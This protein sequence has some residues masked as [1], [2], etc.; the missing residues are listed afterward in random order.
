VK[1]TADD[2]VVATVDDAIPGPRAVVWLICAGLVAIV[3]LIGAA[4]TGRRSG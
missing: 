3:I 1:P 4:L 2:S